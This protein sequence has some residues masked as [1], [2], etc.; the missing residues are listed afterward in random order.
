MKIVRPILIVMAVLGALNFLNLQASSRGIFQMS[1][2]DEFGWSRV[3][4]SAAISVASLVSLPFVVAAGIVLDRRGGRLLMIVGSILAAIAGFALSKTNS[5]S[6]FMVW[7]SAFAVGGALF[8]G[9]VPLVILANWF[10]RLRGIFF[11]VIIAC[12]SVVAVVAPPLNGFL[13]SNFGWRTSFLILGL[14]PLELIPLALFI[15]RRPEDEGS[16]PDFGMSNDRGTLLGQWSPLAAGRYH[17]SSDAQGPMAGLRAYP[18]SFANKGTALGTLAFFLF[19]VVTA[20]AYASK[21][22]TATFLVPSITDAGARPAAA[23]LSLT[24]INMAIPIGA[25]VLGVL[26]DFVHSRFCLAASLLTFG[27][28]IL[29]FSANPLS[30]AAPLFMGFGQGGLVCLGTVVLADYFGRGA[31]GSLRGL[32]GVLIA[33]AGAIGPVLLGYIYASTGSYSTGF[34]GMGVGVLVCA[35]LTIFMRQPR[36]EKL[37]ASQIATDGVTSL[38]K[39]RTG[40]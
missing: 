6:G 14:F 1:M 11:G 19:L 27:I 3:S 31:L 20:V 16:A 26:S 13:L 25:L 21:D 40:G 17:P 33:V 9:I 10:V 29:I 30:R 2:L 5:Y 4:A 22:G 7:Y 15:K 38:S 8:G 32:V 35:V 12:A 39:S 36:Y 28:G 24:A 18:S 34:I 23:A 37:S